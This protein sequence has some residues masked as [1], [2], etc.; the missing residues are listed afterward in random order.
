MY[1]K[2]IEIVGFKSFADKTKVELRPGI[3][4]VAGPNGCGKSNIIECIRWCVGESSWKSL[5]SAAMTDVIFAGTSRRK[6]LSMA[7]VTLTLDNAG[8]S[9][10]LREAEISVSRRIYRSGENEYFINKTQCRLKDVRE[11]FLDT[12]IGEQGY[13]VMDQGKVEF[14][15]SSKPQDR[16]AIFEEAAGVAKYIAKRQEALS[17]LEKVEI[18]ANR[19]QDSLSLI[20]EQI[21]KLDSDARKAKLYKRFQEDLKVMEVALIVKETGE[22]NAKL[23]EEERSLAPVQ[24][25]LEAAHNENSIMDADLAALSLRRVEQEN[26]V[27]RSNEELGRIRSDIARSEERMKSGMDES[28]YLAG[29]QNILKNE[30]EEGSRRKSQILPEIKKSAEDLGKSQ[31]ALAELDASLDGCE[32]EQANLDAAL[33]DLSARHQAQELRE[34]EVSQRRLEASRRLSQKQS[35]FGRLDYHFKMGVKEY[36]RKQGIFDSQAQE[37]ERHAGLL[38]DLKAEEKQTL[39]R[40]AAIEQ[41]CRE[42]AQALESKEGELKALQTEAISVSARIEA[43]QKHSEQDPYV[44]GAQAVLDAQM[45]GVLGRLRDLIEVEPSYRTAIQEALGERLE[46]LVCE[47]QPAAESAIEF[48]KGTSRGRARFLLLSALPDAGWQLMGFAKAQ[49]LQRLAEKIQAPPALRALIDFLLKETYASGAV[50]HGSYW[51][52]GGENPSTANAWGFALTK[53][54][55]EREQELQNQ[56]AA[57]QGQTSDM[58]RGLTQAQEQFQS[59]QN[60]LQEKKARREAFAEQLARDLNALEISRQDRD[61]L[62]RDA[63]DILAQCGRVLAEIKELGRELGKLAAAEA[64]ALKDTATLREALDGVR[65]SLGQQQIRSAQFKAAR[66]HLA[67]NVRLLQ[68]QLERSEKESADLEAVQKSR[69]EEARANDA[70]L[71]ELAALQGGLRQAL[72]EL[73]RLFEAKQEE[74]KAL[75]RMLEDSQEQSRLK[76]EA[77]RAKQAQLQE[78]QEEIHRHKLQLGQLKSKRDA[79]LNQLWDNWQMT[80]EDALAHADDFYKRSERKVSTDSIVS[81]RRRIENMGAINMAAPEEYDALKGRFDFTETQLRDLNTA[82]TEL[83]E[84]IS[85]INTTTRENFRE[86]FSQVREHFR[87]I[88]GTLFQGGEADLLLTDPDNILE[89]GIEI[90]AQPPGKKLQ[91]ISLLSGGEKAMTAVALLFA[92]FEVKPAPFCM[93]DEVDAPLDEPN[94]RRFLRLLTETAQ[95]SQF[96]IV[97]HNKRTLEGADAIYGVTMEE[98]GVSQLISIEIKGREK[99]TRVPAPSGQ[100]AEA[101]APAQASVS[102]LVLENG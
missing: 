16:R 68:G 30:L 93:M 23:K 6:P 98:Q 17:K 52:C 12:G 57:L 2:S 61:L 13:S 4:G 54:L 27:I 26:A 50:T 88:Y 65:A 83:K 37:A 62:E 39:G 84:A 34:T 31:T 86:T 15:L 56:V 81:L 36:D 46:A 44:R 7:E 32:R 72:D 42:Q 24:E 43:A 60:Q 8:G 55:R 14:V 73:H 76:E 70:R 78:I 91:S 35:D 82:K 10:P 19:V 49:S 87:S 96:L 97:S 3:T 69:F 67:S 41:L 95:A 48:L 102:D 47:G 18:D 20:S 45:P 9:L 5:R 100:A 101:A 64:Q 85:K 40:L 90:V 28:R 74:G 92:F 99:E 66:E 58:R 29:R 1:L 51:L 53:G 77:L 75:T 63:V 59:V 33:N 94:I 80:L 79:A 38:D 25:R 71:E 22:L 11:L 21:K 89:S